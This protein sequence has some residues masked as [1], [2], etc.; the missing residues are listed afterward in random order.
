MWRFSL[1]NNFDRLRLCKIRHSAECNI[2]YCAQ[3]IPENGADYAH[4]NVLHSSSIFL[5]KWLKPWL[6]R[7][8]WS[9]AMWRPCCS[10]SDTD[11]EM[12]PEA[13]SS[14]EIR[15]KFNGTSIHTMSNGNHPAT[16]NRTAK[17]EKHKAGMQ[18]RHTL[19]L[20]ERFTLFTFDVNVELTGPGYVKLIIDSIFGRICIL[21]TVTP[22]EPVLQRVTHLIYSP[23]LLAP[24]AKMIF[25]GECLM[26]ARDVAIWHYKQFRRKPI[27]VREDR[28]IVA[29]RRWYLQFYSAQSPTY[30]N[31]TKS[32][33]W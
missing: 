20:L 18:L 21:Q 22:V 31:A 11:A 23:P 2:K 8:S 27:L 30:Q 15:V 24:Y 3:D 14:A 33:Q 7:H 32:L 28:A 13:A 25:L 1:R 19:I 10:H 26:F 12:D 17:Q 16:E 29:Y 4:L 5:T 9:N 6:A